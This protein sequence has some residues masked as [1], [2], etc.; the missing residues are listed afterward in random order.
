MSSLLGESKRKSNKNSDGLF[1]CWP[2]GQ[3]DPVH[4]EHDLGNQEKNAWTNRVRIKYQKRESASHNVLIY[5]W[6]WGRARL[7]WCWIF[8]SSYILRSPSSSGAEAFVWRPI[9]FCCSSKEIED[10]FISSLFCLERVRL[11]LRATCSKQIEAKGCVAAHRLSSIKWSVLTRTTISF[12][13][14]TH[15]RTQSLFLFNTSYTSKLSLLLLL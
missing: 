2:G 9:E 15:T 13:A 12:T 1:C 11:L 5:L 6:T 10:L 4:V 3:K 7:C 14:H 8:T